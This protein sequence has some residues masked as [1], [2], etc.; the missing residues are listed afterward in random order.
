MTENRVET[1][2]HK[3]SVREKKFIE[4]YFTAPSRR[5]AVIQA[6]YSDN[7]PQQQ[8]ARLLN[9]NIIRQAI[10]EREKKVAEELL[11]VAQLNNINKET[12][13]L[14]LN[15]IAKTAGKIADRISADSQICKILGLTKEQTTQN[16]SIF[17]QLTANNDTDKHTDIQDNTQPI[18]NQ[19]VIEDKDK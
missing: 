9:N 7:N 16:I 4:T 10:Q 15:E 18:D 3:L 17:S 11:K 19:G 5:Q 8:Y 12:I 14:R 1:V 6:G 2:R 13:L